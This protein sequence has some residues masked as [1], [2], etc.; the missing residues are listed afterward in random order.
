MLALHRVTKIT[1]PTTATGFTAAPEKEFVYDAVTVDSAVM[2]N[3]KSRL[4]R[5]RAVSNEP[6]TPCDTTS[7]YVLTDLIPTAP[8]RP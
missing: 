7:G 8:P 5:A 1:Y 6:A 3:V 2:A 4:A